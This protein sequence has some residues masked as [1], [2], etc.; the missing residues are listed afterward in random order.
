MHVK[1]GVEKFIYT[2]GKK[3]FG[4]RGLYKVWPLGHVYDYLSERLRTVGR[5][6]YVTIADGTVVYL[7]SEDNLELSI[8]SEGHDPEVRLALEKF[9]RPGDVAVDVGAHIGY[10]TLIMSKLVG[11]NGSV[12]AFEPE[13]LN[14]ALLSK[15]VA[16][17]N[18][19]NAFLLRKA[20]SEKSGRINLYI[21]DFNTGDHRVYNPKDFFSSLPSDKIKNRAAYEKLKFKKERRYR[22]RDG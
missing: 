5:P 13:P 7:D 4:G 3:V 15:N 22:D 21:S 1:R 10:F 20:L 18:I 12:F 8:N 14:F 2:L 16:A 9:L 19:K 17:N 11:E 6:D